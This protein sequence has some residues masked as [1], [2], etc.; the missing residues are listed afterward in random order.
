[1]PVL[2][3]GG[4]RWLARRL[5]LRLIA[6]GGEVRVYGADDAAAL[7]AAGVMVASGTPD[8]EGR[9]DAALTDVHTLVHVGPGLLTPDPGQI[10]L[11]AGVAARAATSAGVRRVITL[12]VPGA[13]AA[14]SAPL[15]A[16]KAAEEAALGEVPAPTVIIRTSLLDTAAL[17]DALATAGL[18][19]DELDVEV[20]PL[21]AEDLVELVVA[22]DRARSRA[23]DGTL[24]V[25][26]DGPERL[27]LRAYL[28]RVGVRVGGRFPL[29]GRRVLDEQRAARL[30]AA[31]LAGPWVS[32][33]GPVLD[34]FGFAEHE[35]QPVSPSS[36]S[37]GR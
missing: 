29:I 34:G 24:V 9:L 7:R 13:Q 23:Q 28:D 18:T 37:A 8:D 14:S 27:T 4:H 30:R 33:P 6:E 10:T 22:F 1:M 3:S 31:L 12:S 16:A 35:P 17:H 15:L 32:P 25:A 21:R 11:E 36:R 26:A 5:A 2:I 19:D 20:A